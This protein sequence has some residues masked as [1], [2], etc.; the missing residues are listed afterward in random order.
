MTAT[1]AA[2]VVLSRGEIALK[3]QDAFKDIRDLANADRSGD[4]EPFL[5]STRRMLAQRAERNALDAGVTLGKLSMASKA[6]I[7]AWA[8]Q[9]AA[10]VEAFA[11]AMCIQAYEGWAGA[12]VTDDTLSAILSDCNA[13]PCVV[14]PVDG[15]VVAKFASG[16]TGRRQPTA[17]HL[18]LNTR[19]HLLRGEGTIPAYERAA[20]IGRLSAWLAL[21]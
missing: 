5:M 16:G 6:S 12:L 4:D 20:L 17:R 9:A 1:V 18:A 15:G 7:T 10:I 8:K 13:E 19:M 11:Q 2:P 14:E 3:L 21:N